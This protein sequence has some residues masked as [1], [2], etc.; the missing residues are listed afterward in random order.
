[1]KI[2]VFCN[3]CGKELDRDLL[4]GKE[5]QICQGCREVYYENPLPVASVIISNKDR[6]VLLVKRAREPFMGMWCFPIGFAETGESIED[7][8]LRELEEETGLT[9]KIAQLVDVSSHLNH[10][11]GELLI[12]TFEAERVA[13]VE[14]AGDD[15]SECRY[16]P[17]MNLPK[18]AFDSQE[19][20]I[21]KYRELKRD[22]W[23]IRDSFETF[24]GG[25]LNDKIAYPG[26]LLSDELIRAVENNSKKIIQLWLD[27][28]MTNPSTGSYHDF[29]RKE[30]FERAIFIIGDFKLWLKGE[31]GENE[32]KSFY[33]N[34]GE[35]RREEKVLLEDLVSS[36][37]LLKKHIWMFTY[38]FGVWEKAVDIYRMFELGE[39]LVYFFDKAAYYAVTG[40]TGAANKEER[41]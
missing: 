12:I 23:S 27:D 24:V 28:I 11:Y 17:I 31:K 26:N 3:F 1:M 14:I 37:S 20:A 35:K 21:Q 10:F 39:R 34:L 7:A 16:F 6:E 36:L 33:V 9:G 32:F 13:G 4:D 25:A 30:L 29:D 41:P 38:S 5:R 15:A 40:Y 8:A 18:L 19:R 22:L 2:K